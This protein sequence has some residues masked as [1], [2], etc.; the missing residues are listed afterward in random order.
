MDKRPRLVLET[1]F[2]R[3]TRASPCS[4]APLDLRARQPDRESPTLSGAKPL[5]DAGRAGSFKSRCCNGDALVAPP[6]PVYTGRAAA[7][8]R[9]TE[10]AMMTFANQTGGCPAIWLKTSESDDFSLFFQ[11]VADAFPDHETASEALADIVEQLNMASGCDKL[12]CV[13]V[14]K[15]RLYGWRNGKF[16]QVNA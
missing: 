2:L 8:M 15:P 11:P 16:Q 5:S 10:P 6:L 1:T 4:L 3:I 14:G 13:S 12:F 7:I 9:L